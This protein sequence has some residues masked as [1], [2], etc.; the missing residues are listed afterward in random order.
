MIL[1]ARFRQE[2]G[3]F[4]K[5]DVLLAEAWDL[6]QE[7]AT[8]TAIGTAAVFYYTCKYYHIQSKNLIRATY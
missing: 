5:A 7:E 2:I 3:E 4:P 1:E 6:L 8:I